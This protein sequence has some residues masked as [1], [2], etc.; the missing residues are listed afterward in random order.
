MEILPLVMFK[1]GHEKM[2]SENVCE[3]QMDEITRLFKNMYFFS[4]ILWKT[5]HPSHGQ[6]AFQCQLGHKNAAEAGLGTARSLEI[7]LR[8]FSPQCS[9]NLLLF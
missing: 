6:T 2:S 4:L 7:P 9:L 1:I 3:D 8:W 5:S